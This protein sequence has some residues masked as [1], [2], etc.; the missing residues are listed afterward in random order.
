YNEDY[1]IPNNI[2]SML[3]A[4]IRIGGKTVGVVCLEHTE[5]P[6]TWTPEEQIFI[7]SLSDMVSIALEASERVKTQQQLQ[8]LNQE[9]ERRVQERTEQVNNAN[10]LLELEL[11]QRERAEQALRRSQESLKHVTDTLPVIVFQFTLTT[12]NKKHL[13]FVHNSTETL[14]G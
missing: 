7:G 3:D 11:A 2:Y 14:L 5:M 13:A 1:L 6:R 8:R 12:D 9:L 10:R 4:P